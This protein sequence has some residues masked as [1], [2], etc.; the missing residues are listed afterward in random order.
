MALHG[1]RTGAEL[2]ITDALTTGYRL[3]TRVEFVVP[4]LVIGVVVHLVVI[5]AF[6][7][8]V[9][10]LVVGESGDVTAIVGG[11][12][13]ALLSA[14]LAAIL[15]G[16][17]LNLYGQVWA[18][19]ASVGAPPSISDTFARVGS[20]WM[21]ILGAGLIVGATE[22][23]GLIVLGVIAALLGGV[24]ALIFLVGAVGLVFVGLRLSMSGWLAADGSAAMDAVQGS[25]AMTS[26]HLV[27]IV[28]WGLVIAI[29]VGIITAIAGIIL[30]RIPLLGPA[31]NQT[32]GSAFGFGAGVTLYRRVKDA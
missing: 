17:I 1:G 22:V 8:F 29:V 13:A 18:T 26:R 20:R 5:A 24:G 9:V 21:S 30:D 16:I 14:I 19:M 11:F 31:L 2:T 7:P 15:G 6:V 4:I 32:L 3:L 23:G 28:V 25:W 12:I 27:T 10:H